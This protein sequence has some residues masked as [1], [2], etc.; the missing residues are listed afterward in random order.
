MNSANKNRK[1]NELA[2]RFAGLNDPSI[3]DERERDV[4]L[5]AYTF[6]SIVSVYVFFTLGLLFAVIGAGLWT[7]PIVLGSAVISIAV[8]SYCKREGIDFTSAAARVA[9]KRLILSQ[10]V[11]AIIVILWLIAIVFHQTTGHPLI[12]VGLGTML[13]SSSSTSIII[14]AAV[15]GLITIVIMTI[16]R[17]RKI[18]QAQLEAVRIDEIEDED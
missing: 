5:R 1:T 10:L 16:S 3:G 18:R 8:S 17:R 15:G 4:I 2:D 11:S 7:V 14:G 9:P 13:V 12:D 6:G